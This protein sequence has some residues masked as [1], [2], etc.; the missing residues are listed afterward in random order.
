MSDRMVRL[1]LLVLGVSTALGC[2]ARRVTDFTIIS[3][4][5]SML[6]SHADKGPNRITGED[7]TI[8]FVGVP[9]MKSAIDDAVEKAGPGYDAL[10]DGVVWM[11]DKLLYQCYRVEGTPLRAKKVYTVPL[12]EGGPPQDP[13]ADGEIETEQG[14][15]FVPRD[16]P[17]ALPPPP[18]A[19]GDALDDDDELDHSDD[20]MR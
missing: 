1:L 17:A 19:S 2:G 8:T 13:P 7:C 14:N 9:N 10:V 12:P 6:V 18:A 4:K 11:D 16:K 20:P 3:T 5:N 15:R